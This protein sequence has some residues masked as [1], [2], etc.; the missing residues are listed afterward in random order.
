MRM[1]LCVDGFTWPYLGRPQCA[2]VHRR[3]N[4]HLLYIGISRD[5]AIG[6]GGAADSEINGDRGRSPG[7]H[8]ISLGL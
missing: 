6:P 3:T 1:G 2:F 8:H 7:T 5:D 4:R